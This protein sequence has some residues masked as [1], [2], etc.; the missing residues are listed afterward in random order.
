[1]VSMSDLFYSP[2]GQSAIGLD[3]VLVARVDHTTPGRYS[4]LVCD[5]YSNEVQDLELGMDFR[6]PQYRREVFLRFYEFCLKYRVHAGASLPYMTFPFLKKELNWTREELLWFIF[7]NGNTQH[8]LTSW[9]I[10]KRFPDFASLNS[11]A[12][13]KWYNTEWPRL[14]FDTDRRHQKRDFIKSVTRYKELCRN[15]QTSF[16]NDAMVSDNPLENFQAAWDM[17]REDFYSFGRM[18]TFSYLEYLR[19]AKLN[20]E[21]NSLFLEDITG[22]KSLRNGL[23]KVLGRDDLDWTGPENGTGFEGKYTPEVM[24]WLKKEGSV[25][26]EEAKQRFKGRDFAWDVTYFTLESELCT[27]KSWHR[28]NRRYPGVYADMFYNRIKKAE[29]RWPE[30]DFSIFWKMRQSYLPKWLRL[31]DNPGDP[32]LRPE[33]QNHYRLTGVPVMMNQ[34]WS[35]FENDFN[36][37]VEEENHEL[38]QQL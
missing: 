5:R 9:L 16:F 4:D 35:C 23:A 20:I 26:L 8:P 19:I 34:D 7:I 32:G 25:L 13:A 17:V 1:M 37:K 38:Q 3:G 18:S 11:D 27:Y 2:F 36:K 21:P 12:L 24:G 31:E 30:E 29:Q 33:K 28:K 6:Q 15:D 14:E 10:F 22:S